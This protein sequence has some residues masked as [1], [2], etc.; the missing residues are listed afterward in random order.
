MSA[1]HVAGDIT[2]RALGVYVAGEDSANRHAGQYV[3]VLTT[4][5]QRTG[6]GHFLLHVDDTFLEQASDES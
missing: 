3:V 1:Q 2:A 6:E 4:V 5:S